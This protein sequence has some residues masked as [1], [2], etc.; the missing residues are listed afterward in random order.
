[1]K[2]IK[3]T[4]D[5][6]YKNKLLRLADN[7]IHPIISMKKSDLVIF[8]QVRRLENALEPFVG[9]CKLGLVIFGPNSTLKSDNVTRCNYVK[10][11]I[12]YLDKKNWTY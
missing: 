11:S 2:K 10:I 9:Y 12:E 4:N 6:A 5:L 3:N 8:D 7:G 1:M